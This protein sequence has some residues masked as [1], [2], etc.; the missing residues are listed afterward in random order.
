M[1]TMYTSPS[2]ISY[3]NRITE[4]VFNR[5]GINPHNTDRVY[6]NTALIEVNP[7]FL[8]DV[9]NVFCDYQEM[10]NALFQ[11]YSVL[12]LVDYLKKSHIYYLEKI[13]PE[14]GQS[15]SI[16]LNNCDKTHPLLTVL[17][18]F[19]YKYKNELETHF[20]EEEETLFPYAK[21]LYRTTYF[22]TETYLFINYL[23]Q[24]SLSDF[25]ETHSDT[26]KEL[27]KIKAILQEYEPSITNKTSFRVLIEQLNNF[28]K[29]L[30]IHAFIE[31]EVLMPK[32][33]NLEKN[34]KFEIQN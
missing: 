15:I 22:K 5:F 31:D 33:F 12:V 18:Q 4:H 21:R 28:E 3:Q 23:Q 16:L 11:K 32:L 10:N 20:F 19:Y 29:D 1:I 8:V 2:E 25:V 14:I 17:Y 30:N 6:E 27:I 7:N 26:I 24:F 9:L 13:L 34:I